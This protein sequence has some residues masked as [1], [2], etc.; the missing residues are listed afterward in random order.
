MEILQEQF[1]CRHWDT[2]PGTSDLH[3]FA[4]AL[5]FPTRISIFQ[6]DCM[7]LLVSITLVNI[8]E[9]TKTTAVAISN[10]TQ[11]LFIP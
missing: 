6:M 9:V 10:I 5:H 4:K 1:L 8:V 2:N 7:P 11:S 3:F